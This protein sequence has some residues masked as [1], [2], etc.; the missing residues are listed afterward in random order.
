MAGDNPRIWSRLL[1][2]TAFVLLSTF[3][4]GMA[5]EFKGPVIKIE[6]GDTFYVGV[7]THR[8]IKVRL[9]GVDSPEKNQPGFWEATSAL[10]A[11]VANKVVHC[12]E[13]RPT[14]GTPCDGRSPKRSRDRVVAQCFIGEKD[15][16]AKMIQAGQACD[17]P[18][19]SNGHYKLKA[20]T[21]VRPD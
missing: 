3:A 9:C 5:A 20:D 8:P 7:T 6:D 21:C 4:N 1:C 18:K 13:V 16:A 14:A 15:I 19:F 17:W 11:M 12:I 2:G 10:N